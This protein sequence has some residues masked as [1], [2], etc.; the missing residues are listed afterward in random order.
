MTFGYIAFLASFLGR[1]QPGRV[2]AAALLFSAIA[3]SGNGLQLADG[4]DGNI[5]DVLLGLIVL[6]PLILTRARPGVGP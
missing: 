2:V 6:V 1:H 3:L 4:L 5:V